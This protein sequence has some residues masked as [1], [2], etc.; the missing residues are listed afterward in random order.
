[1]WMCSTFV[2]LLTPS[3]CAGF[4]S[5]VF[6]PLSS[7]HC[8]LSIVFC[9]LSSYSAVCVSLCAWYLAIHVGFFCTVG[10]CLVI[11]FTR[12]HPLHPAAYS[13]TLAPCS[14]PTTGSCF[15]PSRWIL[16]VAQQARMCASRKKACP[17]RELLSL[18][19]PS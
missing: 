12:F 8:L 2:A 19:W 11:F 10:T 14:T 18:V 17:Q 9:P 1:M 16:V 15:P 4:L 13:G 7:V 5:I 3:L 6:C